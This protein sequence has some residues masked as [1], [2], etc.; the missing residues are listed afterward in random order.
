M[1]LS[2]APASGERLPAVRQL[3][4]DLSAATDAVAKAY[5]L[6]E[7]EGLVLSRRVL[8][9]G[10]VPTSR[11]PLPRTRSRASAHPGRH[12]HDVG[13]KK[14]VSALRASTT[15]EQAALR[16]RS[17]HRMTHPLARIPG[18]Q[19]VNDERWDRTPC[20]PTWCLTALAHVQETNPNSR[21]LA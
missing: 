16:V 11:L 7:T 2:G 15:R 20:S 5:R 8:A 14:T 21:L 13:L 1:I 6:L 10:S 17:N 18:Q 3:A 4:R 12:V 19:L 9:R